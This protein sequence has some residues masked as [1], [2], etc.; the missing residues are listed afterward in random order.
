MLRWKGGVRYEV[1]VGRYGNPGKDA[2]LLAKLSKHDHNLS[3][4]TC[5]TYV[6][7]GEFRFQSAHTGCPHTSLAAVMEKCDSGCNSLSDLTKVEQQ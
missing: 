7:R 4:N 2:A 1:A 5:S 3:P 6:N